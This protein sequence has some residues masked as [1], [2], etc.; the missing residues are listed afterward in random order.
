[1]LSVKLYN[2]IEKI[3]TKDIAENERIVFNL[4]R[5][6]LK[7]DDGDLDMYNQNCYQ[8]KYIKHLYDEVKENDND[9]INEDGL[10]SYCEAISEK[11]RLSPKTYSEEALNNWL[12]K[13]KRDEISITNYTNGDVVFSRTVNKKK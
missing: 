12:I 11:I 5:D 13:T 1:M 3:L 7:G 4:Y 8:F 10:N 6:M 9:S 2:T